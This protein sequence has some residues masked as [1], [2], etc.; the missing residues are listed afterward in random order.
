M[1]Q[2]CQPLEGISGQALLGLGTTVYLR[3]AAG[4]SRLPAAGLALLGG[5]PLFVALGVYHLDPTLPLVASLIL[6][7]AIALRHGPRYFNPG[8]PIPTPD[9]G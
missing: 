8:R 7:L 9:R 5:L 3:R 6:A 1:P 4:K 2:S